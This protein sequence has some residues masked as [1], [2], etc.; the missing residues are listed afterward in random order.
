MRELAGQKRKTRLPESR[1]SAWILVLVLV[2]V[3]VLDR[4]FLRRREP[5][6]LAIIL[7]SLSHCQTSGFLRTKDDEHDFAYGEEAKREFTIPI[8]TPASGIGA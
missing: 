1:R 6:C 5:D 7:S 3:L 4:R 8:S 2:V